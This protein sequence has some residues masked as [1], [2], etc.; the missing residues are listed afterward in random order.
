[1][2]TISNSQLTVSKRT[3][4]FFF[5]AFVVSLLCV[6]TLLTSCASNAKAGTNI[7]YTELPRVNIS[8]NQVDSTCSVRLEY[9]GNEY[10][11]VYKNRTDEKDNKTNLMIRVDQGKLVDSELSNRNPD[12]LE[13]SA[14]NL[15]R[16]DSRFT[17]HIFG[18]CWNPASI[19]A[20][21]VESSGWTALQ[22]VWLELWLPSSKL[23]HDENSILSGLTPLQLLDKGFTL[24]I[25]AEQGVAPES[26]QPDIFVNEQLRLPPSYVYSPLLKEADINIS[27]IFTSGERVRLIAGTFVVPPGTTGTALKNSTT[28]GLHQYNVTIDQ[29]EFDGVA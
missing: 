18:S 1:M 22:E 23:V 4:N 13:F 7:D 3:S 14:V 8:F 6:F 15:K 9:K 10:T 20:E 12:S 17:Y 27:C 26:S 25:P 5:I 2:N 16:E 19:S 28:A 24:T 21:G 29:W 11:E